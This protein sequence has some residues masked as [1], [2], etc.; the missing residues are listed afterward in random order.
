MPDPDGQIWSSVLAHLRDRTP[1]ICRHWFEQLEPL[2]L[3]GGQLSVRAPSRIY[4]DYLQRECQIAFTDALQ[5]VSGRLLG[6]RFLGPDDGAAAPAPVRHEAQRHAAS[7]DGNLVI[8]P[9]Y[10]FDSFVVGPGNQLAH[11]AA[12]AVAANPG[13]SYNPLFIHGGVGLGKTHLLQAICLKLLERDPD[14]RLAYIPCERFL[15]RFMEAVQAGAMAD[16]RHQFRDVDTLVIDDIHFLA[17]RDRT[18]EEFFHTFNS[19]YQSSKQ[20]VLSSDA[21]PG[22][23]QDLEDRLVSRF[24]WG[25]VAEIEPP[26]YETRVAIVKTKARMRG[27]DMPDDVACHVAAKVDTHIRELEG[28]VTKLQ[29]R[30]VVDKRPIDLDM[31]KAAIGELGQRRGQGVTVQIIIDRVTDFYGVRMADLQSK[32]R[33]RSITI[34]RQIC[35]YLVRRHTDHSYE[36]IGGYFGGR[37]HTTVMHAVNTIDRRRASDSTFDETIESIEQ[38]FN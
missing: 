22:D 9:D 15:T 38:G 8:S 32:K 34:P 20:L 35:M 14:M 13:R 26:D 23:I 28:A 10:G 6:I 18:Q 2:G 17:K 7:D 30:S 36:E 16:F 33:S 19:L 24:K 27:I 1:A 5:H 4:R 31:A 21:A 12:T 29:I 25:L 11:A 3:D 37:D